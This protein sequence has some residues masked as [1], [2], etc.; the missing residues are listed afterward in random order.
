MISRVYTATGTYTIT[1]KVTDAEGLSDTTTLTM[2]VLPA[3]QAGLLNSNI[4]YSVSWNRG[5]AN[6]D[7]LNLSASI[8]TGT[9]P[10]T[11]ASPLSLRVVGQTFSGSSATKLS[12]PL[13]AKG[14]VQVKFQLAHV[15]KKG[16]PPGTYTL[17]CTI[18]HA[19]LGQ[20][21]ALAGVTGTKSSTAKIPIRLG[22]GASSFESSISSQFRFGGNGAKANGGG[23]GPK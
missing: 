2:V 11:S 6:A 18:K 12:A 21:F 23:Q 4:K 8:N 10:V 19:S 15:V 14:G 22:I 5:A 20:A 7:T 16:A 9:T 13:A 3:S 17:K 1:L